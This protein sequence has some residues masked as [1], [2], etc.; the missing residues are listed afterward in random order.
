MV[1]IDGVSLTPK[2]VLLV[3]RQG[4]AV[5]LDERARGRVI[6][7]SKY[8]EK[9]AKAGRRIYGLNNGVGLLDGVIPF[10]AVPRFQE[11]MVRS[12]AAGVGEPIPGEVVRAAMLARANLLA[13]GLSGVSI[14]TL[15]LLLALLNKKVTPIAPCQ[16]SLGASGDLAPL[17]HIALVLFG[18]GE[19]WVNGVRMAG[20]DALR[21]AGL[22]PVVLTGR[23][24][25][26]LIN[27]TQATMAYGAIALYDA[28]VAVQTADITGALTL[29]ALRARSE[30]FDLRTHEA[31]AHPGQR[32]AA[33][34]IRTLIEGSSRLRSSQNGGQLDAYSLRCIP[35]V[36][37]A[38]RDAVSPVK[39]TIAVE[40]NAASDNPLVFADDATILT[41]GNFHGEL[42][43]YMLDF[44]GIA[45]VGLMNICE[46][47]ISRML[48]A[49]LSGLPAFLA[50]ED[51]I[52]SGMVS[53]QITAASLVSESK[54]L[55]SPS[56]VDS[57]PA[58]ANYEDYVSMATFSSRKVRQIVTNLWQ[59]LAIEAL[60]AVQAIDISPGGR[61]GRGTQAAYEFIRRLVPRLE[62][63]REL[64]PD[65]ALLAG[66]LADG[67]LAIASR[68]AIEV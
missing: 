4:E 23:D 63:D 14:K 29:E 45:M 36:H 9:E 43:G 15:E 42:L 68:E 21:R 32:A 56:S 65:I 39:Q 49:H 10:E 51:N 18:R 57:I 55:A 30:P 67:H 58:W 37:G 52:S 47:R 34:F 60:C 11:N 22:S 46:R 27:G 7:A 16:G 53:A 44:L 20:H 64:S 54:I 41:G 62:A 1:R 59:V 8:L 24:G 31:H 50:A 26:A 2:E 6:A 13:R 66:A 28:E 19:A 38:V 61:L 12:T 48:D 33:A 3:A 40:L 25:S 17:A 5:E 35:Q